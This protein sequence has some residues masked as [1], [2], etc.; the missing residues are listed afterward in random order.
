V[1]AGPQGPK[2]RPHFTSLTGSSASL[3]TFSASSKCNSRAS[4]SSKSTSITSAR[5]CKVQ[6]ETRPTGHGSLIE[7]KRR[8]SATRH[9]RPSRCTCASATAS[10]TG[11]ASGRSPVIRHIPGG[12]IVYARVQKVGEPT[13]NE[14]R[15]WGVHEKVAVR[16][17]N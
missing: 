11:L 4:R 17:P 3:L 15:S 1:S 13:I 16:R 2:V 14:E 12:K 5:P 7:E 9:T 10:R 6:T 8:K